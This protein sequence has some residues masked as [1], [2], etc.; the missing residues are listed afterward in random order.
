MKKIILIVAVIAASVYAY[1]LFVNSTYVYWLFPNA[2]RD[3]TGIITGRNTIYM[4]VPLGTGLFTGYGQLT[5]NEGGHIHA[6]YSLDS[7]SFDLAFRIYAEGNDELAVK[8]PVFKN[9]QNSGEIFGKS[10]ISGKGTLDFDVAPGTYEVH[11]RPHDVVGWAI[12]T[13]KAN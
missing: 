2:W 10:G 6:E 13:E 1:W 11:F 8:S 9:L 5:I 7:G 3:S 4:N 12:V